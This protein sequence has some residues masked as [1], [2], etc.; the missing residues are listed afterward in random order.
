M[1]EIG[2]TK[3]DRARH[4]YR[5]FAVRFRAHAEKKI[6]PRSLF[7]IYLNRREKNIFKIFFDENILTLKLNVIFM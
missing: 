3:V 6:N 2:C 1:L 5:A 4:D 7:F